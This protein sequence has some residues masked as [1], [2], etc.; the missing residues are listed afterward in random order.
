MTEEKE[1]VDQGQETPTRE[2]AHSDPPLPPWAKPLT[3]NL[4]DNK[5]READG[6]GMDLRKRKTV[7]RAQNRPRRSDNKYEGRRENLSP[8]NPE[9]NMDN[10]GQQIAPTGSTHQAPSVPLSDQEKANAALQG[11]ILGAALRDALPQAGGL[12]ENAGFWK[13]HTSGL[14]TKMV[15]TAGQTIAVSAVLGVGYLAKLA[16]SYFFKSE[17]DL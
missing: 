13:K 2:P 14:G 17:V 10:E 8:H 3:F 9:E 4:G 11:Q 16:V 15:H 5:E 1:K 6:L 7:P 12:D